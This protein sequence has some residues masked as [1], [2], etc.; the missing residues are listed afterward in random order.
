MTRTE[1]KPFIFEQWHAWEANGAIMVSDEAKKRLRQ[2]KSLDAAINWLY[3]NG[4]RPAARAL[5]AHCK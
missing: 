1:M 2:F 5:N 3:L 4:A